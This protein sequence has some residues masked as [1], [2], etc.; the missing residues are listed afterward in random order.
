MSD[1]PQFKVDENELIE[2]PSSNPFGGGKIT[3][4]DGEE[5]FQDLFQGMDYY[6]KNEN[7]LKYDIIKI[8]TFFAY[9]L[10]VIILDYILVQEIV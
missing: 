8:M 10:L 7:V 5:D 4:D 6:Q 9:T 1:S 2:R 3:E